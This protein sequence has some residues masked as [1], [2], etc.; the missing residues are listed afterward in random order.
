M[1]IFLDWLGNNFNSQLNWT[2]THT[3]DTIS[4]LSGCLNYQRELRIIFWVINI[5]V[6]IFFY[7][8][9]KALLRLRHFYYLF[10]Y[11]YF[12]YSLYL[13]NT[14]HFC[15]STFEN[16]ISKKEGKELPGRHTPCCWIL[17][18]WRLTFIVCECFLF[19][20]VSILVCCLC[21][22]Y[23]KFTINV[24]KWIFHQV[25]YLWVKL[26]PFCCGVYLRILL[27]IG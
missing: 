23:D 8:Q 1:S 21:Q 4:S 10:D 2:N 13:L 24:M 18:R 19:L 3:H 20:T 12:F 6:L 14:L 15:K 17:M 26:H 25:N 7:R 11:S 22:F 27:P 9:R 16:G 5:I